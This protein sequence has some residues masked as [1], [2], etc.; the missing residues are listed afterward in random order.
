MIRRLFAS[1]LLVCAAALAPR[2]A[3]AQGGGD[4]GGRIPDSIAVLG[5]KRVSRQTVL[6]TAGLVPGRTANYRDIQHAIQTLYASGQFDDIRIDQDTTGPGVLVI[7]VRERPVLAHWTVRAA[8][9]ARRFP[10]RAPC[11]HGHAPRL[12]A[13]RVRRVHCAL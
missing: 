10:A 4:A 13:R 5:T 12:R 2:P 6:V 1:V 11:A 3:R 8:H 7:Q 9:D